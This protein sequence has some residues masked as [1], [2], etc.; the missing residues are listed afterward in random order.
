MSTAST[1]ARYTLRAM[2][3]IAPLRLAAKWDNV[4]LLL[5][6]PIARPEANRV[7]LTI[8][9]TPSVLEEALHP[10][11]ALV[12]SYHPPIFKPLSS[13]T[14]ANPLQASL[15]RLA[16]VGVSVY[17]PHTALDAVKGG[18]NDFLASGLLDI[19]AS[20]TGVE[21]FV[22]VLWRGIQ[23]EYLCRWRGGS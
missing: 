5:E 2:E 16:A 22:P 10:S 11:T 23:R 19:D 1:L 8:D 9:L 4:G 14:L 20:T 12:I 17:S 21:E 6:S 18:I 3:K 13:F 15:L 7:L